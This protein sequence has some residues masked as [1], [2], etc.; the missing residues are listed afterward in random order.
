MRSIRLAL[1][2]ALAGAACKADPVSPSDLIGGTWQLTSFQDGVATPI[3]VADPTRYTLSFGA[4]D[5]ASVKSDCNSC[6]GAYS[7]NGGVFRM[8]PLACTR[9]F[10][11]TT[12]LDPAY[13]AALDK[14]R[15]VTM[16]TPSDLTIHGDG[17]TLRFKK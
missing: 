3:A 4:D 16:D 10:C 9:V 7:L 8:G 2:A 11:G 5:R 15:A 1:V 14:A 12:S 17:V 13:P 6:G